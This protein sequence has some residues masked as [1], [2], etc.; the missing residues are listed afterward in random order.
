MLLYFA[1]P[2]SAGIIAGLQFTRSRH[3][4]ERCLDLSCLLLVTCLQ[5]MFSH[6]ISPHIY[7]VAHCYY[8]CVSLL[9]QTRFGSNS[10]S[11]LSDEQQ[12]LQPIRNKAI[13]KTGLNIA[14]CPHVWLQTMLHN[15]DKQDKL[16]SLFAAS[17]P[18]SCSVC[19]FTQGH[20]MVQGK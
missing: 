14:L 2:E 17:I 10:Q 5:I 16:T 20:A 12:Q 11:C 8:Q 7:N 3:A 13:S 4:S 6:V 18:T 15:Q 19:S 1:F 9:S